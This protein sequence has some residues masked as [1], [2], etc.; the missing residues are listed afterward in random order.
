MNLGFILFDYF[1]FGGLQRDCVKIAGHCIQHGHRVTIFTR[2]WQGERPKGIEV[3]LFGR[4]GWSN[5]SRNRH[6]LKQLGATLPQ[7]GLD[8]IAGFNKMPG[9]DVYYGADPCFVARMAKNKPRWYRWLPRYRHFAELERAVFAP[10]AA[11][12]ILLIAPR[13]KAVYQDIYGTEERF[14]FLPPN[15]ARRTFTEPQRLATRDKIRRDNG[16]PLDENIAL[17]VGSD[18]RRKGVDRAIL[19]LAALPEPLRAL[20]RLVIL[21]KGDPA[22]FVRLA[23]N[24]GVADRVHFL[25]GRLDAPD[26]MLAA[27]FMVHP[28]H[29]ENT[30]TTLVEALAAGLPVLTTEVCGFASHVASA[31]A[32]I[33]LPS[34]FDQGVCNRAFAGMLDP[35]AA[36]KRRT[37]ALAYAAREDIYGCHERAAELIEQIVRQK[38]ERAAVDGP[39]RVT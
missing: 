6:W 26:W 9:L 18:F 17:H 24:A 31:Q 20:T 4:R 34:P 23:R 22:R 10:G 19:A 36:L 3:E 33:V 28:A 37:N 8:G 35:D 21:G 29:S 1:P 11:T 14:H 2:T 7:R 5:V 13:D 38:L 27:D 32:G 25:G 16:W 15:A 30:G 12:Q 39:A